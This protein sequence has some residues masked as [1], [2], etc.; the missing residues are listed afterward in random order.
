[1]NGYVTQAKIF[2]FLE[3]EL[4]IKIQWHLHFY[5]TQIALE[6][7]AYITGLVTRKIFERHAHVAYLNRQKCYRDSFKNFVSQRL[8][9]FKIQTHSN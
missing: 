4:V 2:A 3:K 7:I 5:K 6:R 1:M 8:R 9:I